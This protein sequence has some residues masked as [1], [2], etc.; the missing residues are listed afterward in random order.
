MRF[1]PHHGRFLSVS[2]RAEWAGL[3]IKMSDCMAI[4]T[5]KLQVSAFVILVVKIFV[6]YLQY[7]WSLVPAAFLTGFQVR[8]VFFAKPE[9]RSFGRRSFFSSSENSGKRLP[10]TFVGAES[11]L[12]ARGKEFYIADFALL[13][14]SRARGMMPLDARGS[15]KPG[16]EFPSTSA[17]TRSLS[18][19]M[20]AMAGQVSGVFGT[21]RR[22]KVTAAAGADQ[23][24]FSVSSI[25]HSSAFPATEFCR[26]GVLRKSIE[27]LFAGNA[28]D[29]N[30][31]RWGMFDGS[32]IVAVETRSF[33]WYSR[34]SHAARSLVAKVLVRLDRVF[35]SLVEP[36]SFYHGVA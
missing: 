15:Y 8:K 13:D 6:M 29:N 1:L 25:F 10:F 26:F 16:Y 18:L 35:Q 21:A 23:S 3:G 27:F 33:L 5:E 34:S 32:V 11:L 28:S 30:S 2:P 9:S 17:T 7:F 4:R 36:L 19:G 20:A 12:A 31:A 14:Y 24:A 22:E